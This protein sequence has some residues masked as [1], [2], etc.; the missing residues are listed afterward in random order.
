M[1]AALQ[2]A[3]PGSIVIGHLNPPASGTAQGV[4]AALPRMAAAG[5]RFVRLSDHLG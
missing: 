1:A 4:A 5:F 2:S 3:S